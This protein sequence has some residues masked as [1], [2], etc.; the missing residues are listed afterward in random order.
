M[1]KIIRAVINCVN[2]LFPQKATFWAHQLFATPRK[3]QLKS[4]ELPL[5]LKKAKTIELQYKGKKVFCYEWNNNP[6]S[7][8][9]VLLLIHGWES[10]SAR[11]EELVTHLG[12]H[13]CFI[14]FDAPSLGQSP[15]GNLSVKDY[16]NC[17]NKI[18]LHFRPTYIVAHSLGAFALYQQLALT[19]YAFV[20][21]VV[22]LGCLD[23]F[24]I[25][26]HQYFKML[27]YSSKVCRQYQ[28]Y[29]SNLFEMPLSKYT[30]S[31]A[32]AKV[33][34]AILCIHDT[35][36]EVI[37]YTDVKVFHQLLKQQQNQVVVTTSIGHR[38]QNPIVFK[39]IEEFL[40]SS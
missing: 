22:L 34:N 2:L 27:G 3:G 8:L 6:Q 29:L 33:Q 1:K 24:E 5:F 18:L 17:I 14:A 35:D 16:Q 4:V 21:K 31:E 7:N 13:Y 38:L 37:A 40:I 30:S 19:N 23:R 32:S 25:I 9:P 26:V 28:N 11:W 36:D 39:A 15:G 20:Q 12:N 10:N